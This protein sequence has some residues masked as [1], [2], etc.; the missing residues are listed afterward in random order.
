MCMKYLGYDFVITSVLIVPSDFLV[1]L[2][3]GVL[4]NDLRRVET[5]A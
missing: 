3:G 1:I 5:P 4:R 2:T